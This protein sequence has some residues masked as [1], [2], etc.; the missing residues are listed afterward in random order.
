VDN[1]GG[2]TNVD[3]GLTKGGCISDDLELTRVAECDIFF[4]D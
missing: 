1:I 4:H 3:S 2:E